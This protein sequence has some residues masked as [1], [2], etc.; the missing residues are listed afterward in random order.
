MVNKDIV[1]LDV[2]DDGTELPKQPRPEGIGLISMR[3]RTE[4]VG[5]QYAITAV[6]GA[7]TRVQAAPAPDSG[8]DRFDPTGS[9]IAGQASGGAMSMPPTRQR[10]CFLPR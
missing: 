9:R 3:E 4:E 8:H 2:V 1:N 6:P 10:S 7:E 5:G